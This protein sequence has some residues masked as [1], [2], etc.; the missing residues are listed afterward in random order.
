MIVTCESNPAEV[1][2]LHRCCAR[3]PAVDSDAW[4]SLLGH[5]APGQAMVLP[6]TEE[7]GGGLK[8]FTI[9]QRLTPHVRHRQKYVDV[10]VTERRAFVF[11]A[12]TH[13]R[14]RRARTLREFVAVLESAPPASLGDYLRRGDFSRWIDDVFGDRALSEEIHLE[15]ER[16]SQGRDDDSVPEIVAAVRGRYDLT[17]E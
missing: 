3:C 11:G 12:G 1:E 16:F 5:I 17:D 13:G 8:M 9:G 10:P 7:S 6:I 4:R 14:S 15:E 2:A